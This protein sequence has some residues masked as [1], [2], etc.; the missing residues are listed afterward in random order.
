VYLFKVC[1]DS[2]SLDAMPARPEYEG[3]IRAGGQSTHVCLS[4]AGHNAGCQGDMKRAVRHR[5]DRFRA[6]ALGATRPRNDA[7]SPSTKPSKR[8]ACA[9][10]RAPGAAQL[11]LGGGMPSDHGAD[12]FASAFRS[13]GAA[14]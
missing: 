3:L 9:K 12:L 2:P 1:A 11:G 4:P 6:K 13:I 14:L 8:A 7:W 10:R 5:L